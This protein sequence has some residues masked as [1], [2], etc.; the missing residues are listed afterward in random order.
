MAIHRRFLYA[1]LFLVALGGV[2]VLTQ[3]V[4]LDES[5]LRQGLRL[6]PLAIIAVGLAIIVRRTR[7]SLPAGVLAAVAPGLLLGGTFAIGPKV[8]FECNDAT[9]PPMTFSQSGTIVGAPLVD[10]GTGCGASTITTAPGGGWSVRAG[11]S[12]GIDPDIAAGPT[13]LSIN[14]AGHGGRQL[15]FGARREAW[16]VT[17]PSTL[18][19][20]SLTANANDMAVRLPDSRVGDL[21]LEANASRVRIDAT[22]SQLSELNIDANFSSV[23]VVLPATT[24]LAGS[25][26]LNAGSLRICQPAGTGLWVRF[27]G[28]GP[29][30]VTVAGIR[31]SADQW[32]DTDN[33]LSSYQAELDVDTTFGSVEINPIG[34]C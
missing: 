33:V 4:P 7:I 12:D 16:D 1:G 9:V 29:R 2:M 15:M 28:D 13:S 21:T 32:Q 27:T 22:G 25:L 23:A 14:S 31:W 20:L 17:L 3:L 34:G 10:I 5:T 19:L 26:E 11:S 8:T 18:E 24:H 6:W 30:E